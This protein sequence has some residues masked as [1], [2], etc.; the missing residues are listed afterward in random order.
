P[1]VHRVKAVALD[2]KGEI[3]TGD[4]ITINTGNDPFRVR[5]VSPRIANNLRG[6]QRVEVDVKVPDGKQL[7]QVEL[8]WNETRVATLFE[9]PFVQSVTIPDA[10]GGVGY[11]R[12]VAKLKD[13]ALSIEDVVMVNT[14]AFME[15][16]NVH[17]VELPTTVLVNGKPANDLAL[18]AFKVLDEGKPVKV[19]KFEHVKNL[20]LSIGMAIDTSGSMQPRMSEAQKAGGTFFQ[21]VLRQGD[22][23][24]LVAFDKM[25]QLVQKWSPRATDMHA[26]LAKLRAEDYTALYDAIVFSLYN[27]LGVKG[28]KALVVITDG[29]DTQSKFTFDQ[30]LEY[31]RRA[32]VP[33]YAIGIG[34]RT[35]DLD[36]KMKLN[37]FTAETGGNAYYIERADELSRIYTDIENE[38][39]SQYV[40]GFYPASDVK[41][42][43]WRELTVQVTEGKA[44]TIRGY[45]P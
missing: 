4:D 12:A 23:G 37:R 16:V 18:T 31:A 6:K 33:I 15:E 38:L 45:Y 17:L 3:L 22:R 5:I 39:R 40:L 42:G 28:Q 35:T 1:Q 27:F 24:F 10:D 25:P 14:P 26:G 9:A 11:I 19:T 43:K 32:A 8:Y 13:E 20:P 30:A 44:K 21:R 7:G 41:P 29:R 34:L 2:E 36:A